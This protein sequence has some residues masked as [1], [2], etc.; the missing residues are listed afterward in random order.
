MDQEEKEKEQLNAVLDAALDALDDDDEQ[1]ELEDEKRP[2]EQPVIPKDEP[3]K[4]KPIYGPEKPPEFDMGSF[5]AVMKQ[6]FS[7]SEVGGDPE[8]ALDSFMQQ[9]QSQLASEFENIEAS[10]SNPASPATSDKTSTEKASPSAETP[11]SDTD[12]KTNVDRTI[13]KL[14]NDMATA[15]VT[16]DAE[17][18]P[19]G[20]GEEAML[21]DMMKEF[22][23]MAGGGLNQDAILDGMMQQLVSKDIMYEPMKQ[24]TDRFPSWLEENKDNLS[25]EEFQNRSKQ[26]KCFQKLVEVYESEPANVKKL[27]KLMQDVQEYGQPPPDIIKEIAP[28]LDLDEEGVPKLDGMGCFPSGGE[29][30][31]CNIM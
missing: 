23:N 18:L 28:G 5:D 30:E 31:D 22:E 20:G 3:C 1:Q 14:L 24:V 6:M 7:V 11:P 10:Q 13:S 2:A 15:N 25:E 29:N 21:K 19:E 4:Q 27:M 17:D 26:Y 12:D 9:L 8:A 16:D